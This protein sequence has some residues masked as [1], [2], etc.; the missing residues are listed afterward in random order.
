M[1]V[2]Y[3]KRSARREL[4]RLPPEVIR[5]VTVAIDGLADQPRPPGVRKLVGSA[6]TY[7][8]RVG[9]YRVVYEIA[10]K[11]RVVTVT[12]VR[13]RSDAYQ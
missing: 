9:D 10:D 5:R 1:Y 7:R 8:I 13:H 11:Q 3:I 6:S 12:R 4:L 2:V